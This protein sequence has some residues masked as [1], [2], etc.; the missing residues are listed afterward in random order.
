MEKEAARCSD[1]FYEEYTA[2]RDENFPVPPILDQY[3]R[4]NHFVLFDA[5]PKVI[6]AHLRSRLHECHENQ[7][8]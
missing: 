8:Q 6:L 1:P 5:D 4:K 7:A 3:N 2:L